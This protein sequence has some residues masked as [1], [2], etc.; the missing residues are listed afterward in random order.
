MQRTKH[1][2]WSEAHT[3]TNS[4][5]HTPLSKKAAELYATMTTTELDDLAAAEGGKSIGEQGAET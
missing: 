4:P 3:H 1:A 5:T 2:K